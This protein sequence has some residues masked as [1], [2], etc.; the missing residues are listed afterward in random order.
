MSYSKQ[1]VQGGNQLHW[2]QNSKNCCA[3]AFGFCNMKHANYCR[4]GDRCGLHAKG[5]CK[6]YHVPI[7]SAGPLCAHQDT[8]PL[9]HPEWCKDG[10]ACEF[11]REGTCLYFHP[12]IV[13]EYGPY[14]IRKLYGMCPCTHSSAP[15]PD[16]EIDMNEYN[17]HLIQFEADR[18]LD[19]LMDAELAAQFAAEMA[20]ADEID[21]RL[22]ISELE[23]MATRSDEEEVELAILQD[24]ELSAMGQAVVCNA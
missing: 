22:R 2:C 15:D 20:L 13:C 19:K 10:N 14:C 23:Q 7:C 9:A 16:A 3:H 24:D 17:Y 5:L 11:H 6:F 4:S 21:R 1:S 18:A 12:T 8:C